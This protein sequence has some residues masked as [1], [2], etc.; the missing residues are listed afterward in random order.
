MKKLLLATGVV[1]ALGV[2]SI[3]YAGT[4]T[5]PGNFG[6]NSTAASSSVG[7]LP[8]FYVG[9]GAGFGG[10]ITSK[11]NDADKNLGGG[12]DSYDIRGFA[13]RGFLGYLWAM[14]RVQNLQLGAELGY[15]YYGKNKYTLGP[16]STRDA[17][18]YSGWNADLLA[19][20]KYNLADTGFSVIGK[21]GAAYVNQKLSVTQTGYGV[22][23]PAWAKTNNK[24]KP[25]GVIG[26]GYDINQHIDATVLYYYV[27][28]NTPGHV[29]DAGVSQS[30]LN[31]VASVDAILFNLAYHFGNS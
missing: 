17:W 31:K 23:N 4:F 5:T 15:N 22:L 19:V 16:V 2:T 27:F 3:S 8:G 25:E 18:N 9:V 10:I 26:L 1:L 11:L 28:G 7:T 12:N 6:K 29:S 21:V 30:S 14:P 20:G 13:A 24:I